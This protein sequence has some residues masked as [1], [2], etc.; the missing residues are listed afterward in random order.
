M[1][2]SI[3][4]A[5]LAINLLILVHELGHF[6]VAKR[7][8]MKV[9]VFSIGFGPKIVGFKYKDTE[10][11]LSLILI[12]GYVKFFGDELEEDKDPRKIPGGFFATSPWSRILVCFAGGFANILLAWVLYTVIFYQGKPVIEDFLNTV[13]GEVKTGSV[14]SEIGIKPGDKIIGISGDPVKT[15]EGL[16]RR[17]AFSSKEE[18]MLDIERNGEIFTKRAL[19]RPDPETGIRQLG[20]YS[21]ETIIIGGVLED[22]PAQK[23][24][25]LKDDQIIAINGNK[26]FRLEPLIETIRENEGKEITLTILRNG[27]KLDITAVPEKLEGREFA[28]IGFVPAT[29][30]TVIYTKPWEQFWHDL[31]LAGYTLAGLFTRRVPVRAMSGPIGIVGIIGIS[32]QIGWIPLLSIIALISLNLGI[33]NLLPIPVLDGGHIIFTLIEVMRRKPLSVRTIMKIQNVFVALLIMLFVY[34]TYNDIL[35]WFVKR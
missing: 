6:I 3:I 10:Y 19:M 13:I 18:I 23:V 2:L 31:S 16:V 1:I 33:I 29:R 15:W 24:G 14:A 34:V 17:I 30:W 7:R 35:R 9:E 8:G 5:I 28:A 32:A 12:G 25:L 21:K 4:I 11:K 27:T 26:V 22:S 20:V